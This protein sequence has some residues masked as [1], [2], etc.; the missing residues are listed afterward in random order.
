MAP[1]YAVYLAPPPASALWRFGS[2]V[3]GYDAQTGEEVAPPVLAGFDRESWHRLTGEPRRY[4]FHGTL[5][6]PFRLAAGMREADLVTAIAAACA[7]ERAFLLPALE[8]RALGAFIALMAPAPPQALDALAERM[9]LG[10]DALRAPLTDAERAKRRP[11][12]LTDR[13]RAYLDAYGYPYVREEFRFHMT[14]TG[15]LAGDDL[16]RAHA[17]L[18]GAYVASGARAALPVAEVGLYVQA[19]PAARFRLA[20]RFAFGA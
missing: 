12:R 13:Q 8:V 7:A 14:L 10:L 19:G 5:K 18:A 6:A 17:A 4:G 3:L 9:V 15:P 16:A 20:R 11:E 1:R 2:A